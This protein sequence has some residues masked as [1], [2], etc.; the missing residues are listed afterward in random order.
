MGE[1]RGIDGKSKEVDLLWK[2]SGFHRV[3]GGFWNNFIYLIAF[4]LFGIA[5][6]A[7]ILPILIPYPDVMGYINTLGQMFGLLFVV[8]D[9]GT[10]NALGRFMAEEVGKGDIRKAIAYV[11]F[12][13]WFQAITGLIQITL[14]TGWVFLFLP[15]DVNLAYLIF[16]ILSYVVKQYPGSVNVFKAVLGGFQRFDRSN[17]VEFAQKVFFEMT[18]LILC[19]YLGGKWGAETPQIGAMLGYAIGYSLGLYLDDILAMI[20][21][22]WFVKRILRDYDLKLIDLLVP[23]FKKDIAWGSLKFG[24]KSFTAGLIDNVGRIFALGLV[25]NFVPQYSAIYGFIMICDGIT[26]P[27]ARRLPVGPAFSESYNNRKYYLS[28][29]LLQAT[30]KWQLMWLVCVAPIIAIAVPPTI[31]YIAPHYASAAVVLPFV[32]V[33]RI[34]KNFNNLGRSVAESGDLPRFS[35][36]NSVVLLIA[37]IVSYMVLVHPAGIQSLYGGGF[38]IMRAYLFAEI[39]IP[40]F[41]G[42]L[43]MWY[44]INK[45]I[46]EI[47]I[48]MYQTFGVVFV[49]F[50]G[51]VPLIYGIMDVLNLESIEG[52]TKVIILII[53]TLLALIFIVPN[54]FFAIVGFMAGWDERGLEHFEDAVKMSGPSK[55][56]MTIW[57]KVSAFFYKISPMKKIGNKFRIPHK[58]A[59]QEARELTISRETTQDL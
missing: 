46:I 10:H 8:M 30:W 50:A 18:T 53:L 39:I 14:I 35:I 48:N 33:R 51:Y 29:Y 57:Y 17:I 9:L 26:Q 52:T 56:F 45:K 28:R 36:Y 2:T 5:F 16:P 59:D 13:I 6:G 49:A 7:V 37:K 43:S 11:R 24:M 34:L 20:L 32:V 58:R 23:E 12:F 4:L 40:Q 44:L 25:V 38:D 55:P 41:F 54:V 19:L 31:G 27:L 15:D 21:S 22:A 47:R 3:L 1:K 42:T